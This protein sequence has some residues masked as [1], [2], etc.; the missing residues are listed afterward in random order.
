MNSFLVEQV[1]N[2]VDRGKLVYRLSLINVI[3]KTRSS[4][5]EHTINY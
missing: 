2:S 4:S 5:S 1:G 3:D